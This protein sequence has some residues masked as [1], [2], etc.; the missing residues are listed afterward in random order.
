MTSDAG[1]IRPTCERGAACSDGAPARRNPG[2]ASR[3]ATA[4]GLRSARGQHRHATRTRRT[5]RERGRTTPVRSRQAASSAARLTADRVPRPSRPPIHNSSRTRQ[6]SIP[7]VHFGKVTQQ[8]HLGAAQIAR[9]HRDIPLQ[10]GAQCHHVGPQRRLGRLQIIAFASA[11]RSVM[12]SATTAIPS[13]TPYQR[14]TP[15]WPVQPQRPSSGAC[16]A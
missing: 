9:D 8:R 16:H 10:L 12:A 3:S 14:R 1:A 5:S 6:V 13:T 11:K 4:A 2:A 7:R 15:S